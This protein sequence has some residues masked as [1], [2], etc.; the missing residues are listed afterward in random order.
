[1][2]HRGF[3]VALGL[4]A[5]F[6][7]SL[8]S[9][10]QSPTDA[11]ELVL[12]NAGMQTDDKS[13]LQFFRLR[14][15]KD[16]DRA[17]MKDWVAK[18]GSDL[19]KERE[20]S[21]KELMA[22][23][24]LALPFLKEILQ[25]APLETTRRAELLIK[26]IESTLG[27]E[28]PIAVARLLAARQVA[29]AIEVLLN[30]LPYVNDEWVEEEVL[31]S[32]GDLTVRGSKIDPLLEKGLKDDLVGRRAAAIYILGRR[33]DLDQRETVRQFFADPDPLVRHTA[34]VWWAR[35][36]PKNLADT[37]AADEDLLKK[38][39][40]KTDEPALLDILR[41]RTLGEEDQK[42]LTK[43][44]PSWATLTFQSSRTR[45][46]LLVAEGTP[47]IAFLKPAL[48]DPDT[49]LA[50]RANLC[51]DAIRR[52]PGPA[53]PTAAIRLLA[54]PVASKEYSARRRH[55]RLARVRPVRRR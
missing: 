34:L 18:L 47:A 26:K 33:G 52:G 13:L 41:K 40:L 14:T 1:M 32:L 19:F 35:E 4:T 29:G 23:H 42:R 24:A 20:Q 50:R 2:L 21:T 48:E 7:L 54:R 36:S 17:K 8:P 12:K 5:L 55:S 22:R 38:Q 30:Y 46:K 27:P 45:S 6:F 53:V 51:F 49:E 43:L 25:T 37:A 31:A 15:L 9:Q 3:L 16:E 44:V 11:D 39:N 28:Q 10:A